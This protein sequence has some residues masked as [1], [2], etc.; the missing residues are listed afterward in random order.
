MQTIEIT[1]STYILTCILV[2]H[3]YLMQEIEI[4][5]PVY[6]DCFQ[7][8]HPKMELS[9]MKV[10]ETDLCT[11]VWNYVK[12]GKGVWIEGPKGTGKSTTLFYIMDNLENFGYWVLMIGTPVYGSARFRLYLKEFC[13]GMSSSS[14]KS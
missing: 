9:D 7:H 4:T 14:S 10:I 2:C 8:L 13:K 1:N 3:L 12:D 5:N 11:K 6:R